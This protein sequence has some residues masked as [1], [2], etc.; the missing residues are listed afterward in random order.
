MDARCALN[1][2][3]ALRKGGTQ[4]PHAQVSMCNTA[5]DTRWDCLHWRFKYP[6]YH[7]LRNKTCCCENVVW[8]KN[9][10]CVG[11]V[12]GWL[13][14]KFPCSLWGMAKLIYSTGPNLYIHRRLRRPLSHQL[15]AECN[16]LPEGK[17]AWRIGKGIHSIRGGISR[18]N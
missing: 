12:H 15:G 6:Q 1:L 13:I 4:G 2:G 7:Q 5:S 11:V 14:A 10:C 9:C 16:V 17:K 3:P 8:L 18:V